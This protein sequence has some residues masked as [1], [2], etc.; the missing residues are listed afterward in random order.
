MIVEEQGIGFWTRVQIP[1]T[2]LKRLSIYW[3][4]SFLCNRKVLLLHKKALR[5]GGAL[6]AKE[7]W[8]LKQPRSGARVRLAGLFILW[9]YRVPICCGSQLRISDERL[10]R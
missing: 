5:A 10:I 8:P 2:P 3:A 6:R 9:V 7:V 1:S 4:F